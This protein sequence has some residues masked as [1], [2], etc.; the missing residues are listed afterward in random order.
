[1]RSCSVLLDRVVIFC[2]V[3]LVDKYIIIPVVG[4]DGLARELPNRVVYRKTWLLMLFVLFRY[5]ETLSK[6]EQACSRPM[7]IIRWCHLP[8]LVLG[9]HSPL[10]DW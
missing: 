8:R 2:L 1:M 9:Q 6:I 7:F 10:Q 3:A 4:L 5:F